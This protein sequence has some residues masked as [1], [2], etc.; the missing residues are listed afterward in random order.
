MLLKLFLIKSRI[1]VI[2]IYLFLLL[3]YSILFFILVF[4][5]FLI[6]FLLIKRHLFFRYPSIP[7]SICSNELNIVFS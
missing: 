7:S 2:F 6:N 5:D 3:N 1:L 4:F